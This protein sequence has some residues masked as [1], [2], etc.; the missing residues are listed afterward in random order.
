MA[1]TLL[2]RARQASSEYEKLNLT[3]NAVFW[4]EKAVCLSK[5]AFEDV[6][7]LANALYRD[8][9]Y[10]RAI[11]VLERDNLLE[12]HLSCRYLGALCDVAQKDYEGAI[13]KL[14]LGTHPVATG[15]NLS[16]PS[17]NFSLVLSPE[18]ETVFAGRQAQAR[19][20]ACC[21]RGVA[22]QEVL[23]MPFAHQC[24][25]EALRLDPMCYEAWDRLT[26]N[27]VMEER[28]E[29]DV[30]KMVCE[31]LHNEFSDSSDCSA[32]SFLYEM[33]TQCKCQVSEKLVAPEGLESSS[34]VV[35]CQA[36]QAYTK[37]DVH[38]ALDSSN[39]VLDRDPLH[40]FCLLVHLG[41]LVAL[42]KKNELFALAHE[43]VQDFPE[44]ATS[45][46]AIGC[47]YLVVKEFEKARLHFSKATSL[48]P[49]FGLAWTAFGHAF[50]A[51]GIHDQANTCYFSA[52]KVMPGCHYPLV[53]VALYHCMN[54]DPALAMKYLRQAEALVPTD[55]IICHELATLAYQQASYKLALKYYL[56]ALEV[57]NKSPKDKVSSAS[58]EP[59]LN[60]IAH[61]YRRLRD[62][63]KALEFHQRALALDCTKSST[64][65]AIGFIHCLRG[66][67]DK[68]IEHFHKALRL[69]RQDIIAID[70][71]EKTTDCL[72]ADE[73]FLDQLLAS[74]G[75]ESCS[76]T[77][78]ALDIDGIQ[79]DMHALEE[80]QLT[81]DSS[82]D[83]GN[84]FPD[85][86]DRRSRAFATPNFRGGGR[87]VFAGA[88]VIMA[89]FSSGAGTSTT[90]T[91]A[92][93]YN[94]G[95]RRATPGTYTAPVLDQSVREEHDDS[96]DID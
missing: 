51:D 39:L 12:L 18:D 38:S 62:Y 71:L 80:V 4:A 53:N 90:N 61:C 95:N 46:Y 91:P 48:D 1:S 28:N 34:D 60:N 27:S 70:M 63:D 55:G 84:I 65:T 81:A 52:M 40:P 75:N 57:C 11:H 92:D 49:N 96:M 9:Q 13:E 5:G 45:W 22:Y 10:R 26:S 8:G 79:S 59:L 47:Y 35:A 78:E 85:A 82:L 41:C 7:R 74:T 3:R 32:A 67:F 54:H 23:N 77:S 58:W 43:A 31:S 76:E 14:E 20:A 72:A 89:R 37:Y 93:S 29:R 73:T 6:Y 50:G 36:L 33:R 42:E 87:S 66:S 68:A 30:C 16:S 94:R 15:F 21:L 19:A 17:H 2:E 69:N 25:I 44:Q 86:S 56:K 83:G 64:Y 88:P 24:Y